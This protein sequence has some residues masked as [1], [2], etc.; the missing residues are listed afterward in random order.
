MS[1][2][3]TAFEIIRSVTRTMLESRETQ[4]ALDAVVKSIS[5]KM[6]AEVCSIYLHDTVDGSLRLA[7]SHGL[8]PQA[9]ADVSLAAGEGLTGA[10]F[11][12]GEVLNIANPRQ[13]ARFKF[14]PGLGEDHLN[15][16]LGIPIPPGKA[17]GRGVLILQGR[18]SAPFGSTLEDLAYTLAAQVGTLLENRGGSPLSA[19]DSDGKDSTH[20]LEAPPFLRAQ[21][22]FG[23]IADG[24]VH[25]LQTQAMWDNI[26]FGE[27]EDPAAELKVLGEA[28]GLARGETRWLR[29]R[30]GEI[31]AEMDARIF[32]A[33]EL[34]LKDEHYLGLIESHVR[35]KM[36]AAFAVKLATRELSRSFQDSGNAKLAAR[37][38]DVRDVG[39]RLLNALGEA[40]E[41]YRPEPES[42]A[43][44]IAAAVELL[45]SDLVYL[46]SRKLLGI[47]CETGG[48]TSHAAILARSLDIPCFIGIP[49]LTRFLHPGT[50]VIMDGNSGL[51]YIRPDEHVIREYKRLA[52]SFHARRAAAPH[53]GEDRTRDGHLV[54]LSGHV[55]LLSDLPLMKR[56]GIKSVGLYRSEFFF[57][58]R[59][60]F[61][62]EETQFGVYRQ[63]MD[64]FGLFGVTFRLLDVGGDK[65]LRYF[66]WGKEENPSLG[67]R[68]IRMLLRRPDILT[69]HLRALLRA[70][71]L[72]NTRL[73]IPMVSTLTELR[74]IKRHLRETAAALEKESG[75]LIP[76]PPVGIMVE[77]PSTVLQIEGFLHESDFICLGT[78]DLIQYLF[79]ID[80]GNERVASYHQPYHP[81][82]LTALKRVAD[83]ALAA[84]KPVTV[85]GEM[86][87]DPKALA[88]LLGLSLT[89]L[90]IAPGAA[91]G[92]REALSRLNLKDC[93]AMV[94]RAL[95]L[96][97]EDEVREEVEL[98]TPLP[99]LHA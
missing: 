11:S 41:H 74:E 7:A 26:L 34:F 96:A 44:V 69:P 95:K 73:L 27:C 13:D 50:R 66:D 21:V 16:F 14:F 56:S 54:S 90:S 81:A 15:N 63:V 49:G 79:A 98:L 82:L 85:C 5:E 28:L 70:S 67:W 42:D 3:T 83:A 51:I 2:V 6:G 65:P 19:G 94:Q 48:I 77:I 12:R 68:S 29:E 4:P 10:V 71:Q 36:S 30:A 38:A 47:L 46:Q 43:G 24:P 78:N 57:M 93:E 64:R 1:E 89:S 9:L 91:E 76:I 20:S 75:Q 52:E 60:S 92:V 39:L 40:R 18:E 84:G 87:A 86:A 35:E 32:D 23:G 62:D 59:S 58:I 72:G 8:N 97:T 33:H 88:L 80:R 37:A 45:P 99:P 61:P 31:F 55:S 25:V 22:A 53:A 17:R